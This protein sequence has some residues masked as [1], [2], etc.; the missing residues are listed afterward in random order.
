MAKKPTVSVI[1]PTY[2]RAH[3]IG[4][5]IQS[6]LNQTYQNLEI[7]VVDDGSLDNTK[8]VIE[9]FQKQEKRIKYISYEKNKGGA[10]ARNI[11]I[12]NAKGE[13]I[14]F[15]D[16]D[17][18][19]ISKKI[20]K[21]LIFF[22]KC[23][24]SVGVVYCLHYSQ[25]DSFGYI[26]KV[27]SSNMRHGN[28]YNSLLNGWCPSSTSFFILKTLVFKKS[29][30]FDESL[31]S[32]QD[33]DLW[34]RIAKYYEFEFVEEYL[35]IKHNHEGSQIAKDLKPRLKGLNLFLKKWGDKIKKEAGIN[36][37]NNIQ[38][39]HL[40][41]IYHNA[42]FDNLISF[43]HKEAIKY[44][45][46]LWEL[47]SLSLKDIIKVGVILLGGPKLFKYFKCIWIKI[48]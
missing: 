30:L 9:N 13:Y 48:H 35:A 25:E 2:N 42:V 32:F 6:A 41:T 5:A 18:E 33:Y 17:D 20:E 24:K 12:K 36:V 37:F 34:I 21:Q 47:Q 4:R 23:S 46:Q 28:V 7:I 39:M 44:L 8:E 38:R 15:L 3:L 10:F 14:A 43:H 19:W 29:G 1:I 22:T 45:K 40:S 26:K 16:S 27:N 31:P 11:G